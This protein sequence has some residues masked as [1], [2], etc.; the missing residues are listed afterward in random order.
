MALK[1]ADK[2]PKNGI[3]L[4]T[5]HV[6]GYK[7]PRSA[8]KMDDPRLYYSVL[9]GTEKHLLPLFLSTFLTDVICAH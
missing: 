9:R 4:M 6:H 1:R 5:D 2:G 7:D 8:Q 3:W